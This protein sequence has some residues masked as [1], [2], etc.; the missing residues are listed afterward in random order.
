MAEATMRHGDP[1]MIDYTPGAG[2]V[3]AGQVVLPAT[4][5]A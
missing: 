5:P 2:N 1:L 4:P 3:A